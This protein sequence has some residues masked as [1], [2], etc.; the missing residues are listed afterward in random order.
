MPRCTYLLVRNPRRA[1]VDPVAKD[2]DNAARQPVASGG[3]SGSATHAFRM[4]TPQSPVRARCGPGRGSQPRTRER[5][6]LLPPP[7]PAS[8]CVGRLAGRDQHRHISRHRLSHHRRCCRYVPCGAGVEV[9]IRS[10][11]GLIGGVSPE[12]VGEGRPIDE[13]HLIATQ[14]REIDAEA[15]IWPGASSSRAI[16]RTEGR[17]VLEDLH[18]RPHEAQVYWEEATSSAASSMSADWSRDAGSRVSVPF[19]PHHLARSLGS[20]SSSTAAA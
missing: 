20:S 9:W 11:H 4:E 14:H 1:Y 6:C 5:A 8:D 3:D 2:T 19:R 16:A 7:R 17:V 12:A 15:E 18:R 13:G 10:E